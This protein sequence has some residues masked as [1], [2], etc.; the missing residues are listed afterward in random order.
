MNACILPAFFAAVICDRTVTARASGSAPMEHRRRLC[1]VA[2]HLSVQP[3]A[4]S[5]APRLFDY[6]TI[7]Q[8]IHVRDA[9]PAVEAC[10]ASLASGQVDVPFPMHIAV[11]ESA[12]AGPGDC[13]VK[14]GY[15]E[16]EPTF[17]VKVATV[18]FVKNLE[19]VCGSGSSSCCLP[20]CASQCRTEPRLTHFRWRALA[21]DGTG[22]WH[23][24]C[25]RRG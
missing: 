20:A 22:R 5:A 17:T 23:V 25:V 11:A 8:Q 7:V 4:A 24:P 18:S 1:R 12:A 9:L 2:Q 13:H 16:G 6:D 14:G 21:G 10:F 15:I 3:V 19:K